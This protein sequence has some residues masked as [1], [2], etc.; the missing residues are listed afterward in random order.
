[1]SV[2]VCVCVC[3]RVRMHVSM[4]NMY[5]THISASMY[6]LATKYVQNVIYLKWYRQ[7]PG[8]FDTVNY[9]P[10]ISPLTQ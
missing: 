5:V 10:T 2:C 4:N 3:A 9:A 8:G 7:R 1:M 6:I